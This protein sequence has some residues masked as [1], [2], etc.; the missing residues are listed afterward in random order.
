VLALLL[1]APDV[2]QRIGV[3]HVHRE[4]LDVVEAQLFIYFVFSG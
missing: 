1:E 3:H 2:P 4:R